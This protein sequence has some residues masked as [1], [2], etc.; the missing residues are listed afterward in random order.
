MVDLI[1][2]N[3]IHV[4]PTAQDLFL[5]LAEDFKKRVFSS[6]QARG[7][8]TVA[9]SG[10]DTPKSFFDT[11]T[12]ANAYK[13]D[14]PWDRIKFFFSDERFVPSDNIKSNYHMAYEHLFS[15]VSVLAE[16]IYRI[17]T[18]LGSPV[19]VAKAYEEDLRRA[20]HAKSEECPQFDLIYL[21]LGEDA[22]TASLMP[23]TDVVINY[24]QKS[25][26]NENPKLL[27][28]VWMPAQNMYRITFTPTLINQAMNTVFVVTGANK[29][30]AVSHVL[31][32][33]IEPERYPAQLIQCA[34][35]KNIWYLDNMAASKLNF[36]K[37]IT[38][39]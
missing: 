11:L 5:A 31:E 12:T 38:D 23:F 6:I 1:N 16:N 9:L 32:G 8:F 24:T 33:P 18:E 19:M 25:Q 29:A 39:K 37:S 17:P 28:A 22:H 21:G 27:A 4:F 36:S 15:K 26:E 2:N 7:E 34:Q 20:F 35:N 30:L 3:I 10:G 14:I 13:E